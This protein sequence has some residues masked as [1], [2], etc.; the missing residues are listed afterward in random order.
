ME[1]FTVYNPVKLHFGKNV[2]NGLGKAVKEYGKIVLMVYG[3]GSVKNNGV[4]DKAIE[5]LNS[6]NAEVF[7]YRGV[8]PNPIVEDVDAAAQ[9]GREKNVELILAVGGGSVV[10]S[11]KMISLAMPVNT[12]AWDFYEGKIKP[13]TAVPM[14]CVL[15]LAATGTE[16]NPFAVIQNNHQQRKLG[17][18]HDLMY[19]KH[20]FLDPIYTISVSKEYTAYGI[21]DLIAHCL[22]AYFGAGEASLADRF[23][24]SIIKEAMQYGPLLL[25]NLNNYDL[26]ARIMYAAMVALNKTTIYGRVSADWGVHSIGHNLSLLFDMAHGASLSIAYPAWLKLHC[27]RAGSRI[28]ELGQNLFDDNTIEGTIRKL[29]DFYRSIGSPVRLPEAGIT[30][31]QHQLIVDTMTKHNESGLHHKLSKEDVVEMIKLMW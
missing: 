2:L 23:V 18:G 28:K 10:D 17:M 3:R 30:K 12:T 29:E 25:Q 9:L 4:Y 14:I 8:R 15:T 1:N 11:A 6:I 7:E 19:P 27:N 24:Y 5:Q 31:N 16:M 21:S 20:S 22:E 13:K 26:R